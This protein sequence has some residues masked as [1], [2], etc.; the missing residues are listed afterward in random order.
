VTNYV[1][2]YDVLYLHEVVPL[3]VKCEAEGIM[4][5]GRNPGKC[6]WKR[7]IS[8]HERNSILAFAHPNCV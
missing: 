6:K 7:I 8:K 5:G 4:K 2:I 3:G 1:D